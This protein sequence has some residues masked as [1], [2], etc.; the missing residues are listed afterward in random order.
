[1][2]FR[3][4]D[5]TTGRFLNRD[6]IGYG[7]GLNLY[8][9]ADD[10]PVNGID[11]SG[12]DGDD[13]PPR[14]GLPEGF[15]PPIES[16]EP[17][18]ESRNPAEDTLE[19]I[20]A[21]YYRKSPLLQAFPGWRPGQPID[22]LT[23]EGQYPEWYSMALPA[24]V[25][26]IQGRYWMNRAMFAQSGE[27]TSEQLNMMRLGFAP[28]A[29]AYVRMNKTGES[30]WI[31]AR[32]ELHHVCGGRGIPGFDTPRNLEEVWPWQHE[33]LDPS[34]HTGYTFIRFK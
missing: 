21:E 8:G 24:K 6:P 3:F 5:P 9:Y 22:Q 32:L 25:N 15:W 19:R 12:L 10:D 27:F 11:P 4:Y 7:G 20:K 17:I 14:E 23:E 34:R 2:G 13:E 26:T 30:K 18:P 33:S 29:R 1:L 31:T 16:E 28:E